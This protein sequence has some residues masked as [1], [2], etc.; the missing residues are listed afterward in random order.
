MPV[1]GSRA[2]PPASP[3]RS[4]TVGAPLRCS[5]RCPTKG[6]WTRSSPAGGRGPARDGWATSV[7]PAPCRPGACLLAK[8]SSGCGPMSPDTW[9]LDSSALGKVVIEEAESHALLS[10][11]DSKD[12]LVACELVRVE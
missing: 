7:R 5:S 1:A 2:S 9:Y 6:V 8:R 11:L 4:P 3:S 12:R 10:W